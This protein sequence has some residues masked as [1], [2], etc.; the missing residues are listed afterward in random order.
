MTPVQE[1]LIR[2]IRSVVCEEDLPEKFHIDNPEQLFSLAKDHDVGHF[3]GYAM[4][5]GR[6]SI[7]NKEMRKAFRQQYFM[8]ARR[9]IILEN[10]IKTIQ[11]AFEKNQIDHI[12]LKGAVIRKLYPNPWMRVS[13]DIEILVHSEELKRAEQILV[14]ELNYNVTSEGAHH[15]HV[16]APS[17]Y[18]VDLHFTLTEREERAKSILDDVWNRVSRVD[19]VRHEYQ[20]EDD[21]FYL[22]HV[23]HTATHFKLGGCGMRPVLDTWLLN[24]KVEYDDG[25]RKTLLQQAGLLQFSEEFEKLAAKWFSGVEIRGIEEV[26]DYIFNGGMYGGTQRIAAAQAQTSSRFGYLLRRA[27]PPSAIMKNVGYPIVENWKL[28][29]PFCWVHR[30]IRGI[31]QGK[32]GLVTYEIQKTKTDL[33]LSQRMSGLFAKMGLL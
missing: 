6:L 3:V 23:F 30:L 18:H 21:M 12:L 32:A 1:Q 20:M 2:I 10:E 8:A 15:D 27:F 24:H 7:S 11:E 19:E 31:A 29:L 25:R 4:D 33:E 17:G 26:E 14:K 13:G 28:L 22:F 9:V 5:K 16:T